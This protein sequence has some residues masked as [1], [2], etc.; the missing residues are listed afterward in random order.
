VAAANPP[1][2]EKLNQPD[3]NILLIKENNMVSANYPKEVNDNNFTVSFVTK[4]YYS[5]E[6]N[7]KISLFVNENLENSML[8]KLKPKEDIVSRI[9]VT[10]PSEGLYKVKVSVSTPEND[11]IA[12]IDFWVNYEA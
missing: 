5:H 4:S 9:E 8:L 10:L 3:F 2:R 6:E 7:F 11:E 1:S 12:N